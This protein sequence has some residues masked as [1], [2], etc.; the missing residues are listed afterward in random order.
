M[1]LKFKNEGDNEEDSDRNR[2]GCILIRMTK[3]HPGGGTVRGTEVCTFQSH[4]HTLDVNV[5]LSSC[6]YQ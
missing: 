4:F 3:L 2:F 6:F 1:L 5:G